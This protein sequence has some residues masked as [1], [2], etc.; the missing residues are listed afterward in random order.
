M[1][2]SCEDVSIRKPGSMRQPRPHIS[3]H[4]LLLCQGCSFGS[5][6]WASN[7]DPRKYQVYII[8]KV[9]VGRRTS[10]TRIK[11]AHNKGP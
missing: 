11:G 3:K 9:G 2:T 1:Y 5:L 4:T 6:L 7:L 10:L 8:H